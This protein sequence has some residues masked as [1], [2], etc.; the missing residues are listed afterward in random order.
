MRWSA[1]SAFRTAAASREL[2]FNE[3]TPDRTG[4]GPCSVLRNAAA[5]LS[6]THV[7][8]END[9]ASTWRKDGNSSGLMS[10]KP[11]AGHSERSEES[12]PD[13]SLRSE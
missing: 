3:R 8:R 1:A 6:F 2:S 4:V 12:R 11:R 9:L 7:S 5:R 10:T 13:S